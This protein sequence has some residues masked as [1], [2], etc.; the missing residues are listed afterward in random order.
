MFLLPLLL[1]T[2]LLFISL[3]TALIIVIPKFTDD[4]NYPITK[5][6]YRITQ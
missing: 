5:T 4:C 3:L 2:L 1:L 6:Y